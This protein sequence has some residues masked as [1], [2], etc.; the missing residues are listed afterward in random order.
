MLVNAFN[1]PMAQSPSETQYITP[2]NHI[3]VY[4]FRYFKKMLIA[5][6]LPPFYTKYVRLPSSSDPTPSTIYNNPRFYPFFAHALGALDGSHIAT[7]P[8]SAERAV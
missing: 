3:D 7:T 8:P 5:L 2:V 4:A 6:S 1:V